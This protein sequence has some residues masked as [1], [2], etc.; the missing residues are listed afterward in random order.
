MR[1]R[2]MS[3]GQTV[4]LSW[5]THRDLPE[6]RKAALSLLEFD[7]A[8]LGP[9]QLTRLR[10]HFAAE[11]QA[12]RRAHPERAYLDLLAGVLE[13]RRWHDLATVTAPGDRP[14]PRSSAA[15]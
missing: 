10:E 12:A 15:A 6:D 9:D 4:G 14:C 13:Y 11:V 2:R 7:A 3:S 5:R 1:A 8:H